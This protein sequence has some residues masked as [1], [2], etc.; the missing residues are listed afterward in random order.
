MPNQPATPV[1]CFRIPD[2]L[3][4]E[5]LRV[6]DDRAETATDLVIRALRREVRREG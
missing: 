5:V 4:E 1:R 6:C 3:W 2:D